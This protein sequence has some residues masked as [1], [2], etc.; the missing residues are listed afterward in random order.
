LGFDV[1][2][3]LYSVQEQYVSLFAEI[4]SGYMEKNWQGSL[5]WSDFCSRDEEDLSVMQPL[6]K[7]IVKRIKHQTN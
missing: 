2:S 6:L 3:S 4:W 1:L 7:K 5:N